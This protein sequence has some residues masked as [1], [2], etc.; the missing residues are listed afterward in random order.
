MAESFSREKL[1][2]APQKEGGEIL[3]DFSSCV[4]SAGTSTSQTYGING[5]TTYTQYMY[6]RMYVC[7]YV[8]MIWDFFSL[9]PTAMGPQKYKNE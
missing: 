4:T 8:C 3:C 7:M 6:V 1:R 2:Q 5:M 9:R